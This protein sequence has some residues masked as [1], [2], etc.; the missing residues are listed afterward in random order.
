MDEKNSKPWNELD[1]VE[2]QELTRAPGGAAGNKSITSQGGGDEDT[3]P[4]EPP[5]P[6]PSRPEDLS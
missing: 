1:E 2:T 4:S 3:P 6:S 5:G